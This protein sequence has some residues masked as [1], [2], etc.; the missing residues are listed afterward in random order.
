MGTRGSRITKKVVVKWEEWGRI[1]RW[2]I[3]ML[4]VKRVLEEAEVRCAIDRVDWEA[5]AGAYWR[6]SQGYSA[7]GMD[8]RACAEAAVRADEDE[9]ARLERI[10]EISWRWANRKRLWQENEAALRAG[11]ARQRAQKQEG[12]KEA[13]LALLKNCLGLSARKAS[14]AITRVF[15]KMMQLLPGLRSTQIHVLIAVLESN[16]RLHITRLAEELVME[17][18]TLSRA[19]ACLARRRYIEF[20]QPRTDFRLRIP[21]LS[22]MAL[23]RLTAFV[24]HWT[25]CARAVIEPPDRLV[26]RDSV[27]AA[28]ALVV[29]ESLSAWERLQ[30]WRPAIEYDLD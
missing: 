18:T 24:H 12:K 29:K 19:L 4:D 21:V 15:N 14:R 27:H 13:A 10:V 1:G 22:K 20:R 16:G 26:E 28:S 25:A 11:L 5:V 23:G 3:R 30:L 6:I 17:R 8:A 7:P 2:R 9:K